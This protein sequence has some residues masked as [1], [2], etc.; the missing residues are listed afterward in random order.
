V[1]VG[2]NAL[3]STA[4][5]EPLMNST[6][7]FRVSSIIIYDYLLMMCMFAILL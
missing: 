7:K 5:V 6:S 4:S 2:L 3:L 1:L